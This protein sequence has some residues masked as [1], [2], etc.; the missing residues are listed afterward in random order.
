MQNLKDL[1]K[2]TLKFYPSLKPSQ[3]S[4]LRPIQLSPLRTG[5]GYEKDRVLILLQ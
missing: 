2:L 3:L 5:H 4:P 1:E